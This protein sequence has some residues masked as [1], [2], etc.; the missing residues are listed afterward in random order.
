MVHV[1]E[2]NTT[3]ITTILSVIEAF[4]TAHCLADVTVVADAGMIS[5]ANQRMVKAV[6]FASI[7]ARTS[8]TGRCSPSCG[9]PGPAY[10]CSD[11][12]IYYQY[13]DDRGLRALRGIDES[14]R[15]KGL[16]LRMRPSS[17]RLSGCAATSSWGGAARSSPGLGGSRDG[18]P[19]QRP[20]YEGRYDRECVP[21]SAGREHTP[22]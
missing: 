22:D 1:F 7:P 8:P 2:G 10:E 16:S 5:A 13:R 14:P 18:R 4:M 11:Q 19:E 20:R 15:P 3:D 9:Q 17:N 6:G 12:V 21:A